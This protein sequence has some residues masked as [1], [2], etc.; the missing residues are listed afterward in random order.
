MDGGRA[1]RICNLVTLSVCGQL[2]VRDAF[3]LEIN[4]NFTL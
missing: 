1:I 3:L 2:Q 4:V